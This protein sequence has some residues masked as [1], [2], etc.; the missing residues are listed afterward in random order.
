MPWELEGITSPLIGQYPHH[1]TF[2]LCPPVAI[3][4]RC[5]GIHLYGS[6][7]CSSL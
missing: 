2:L 1:M 3:V 4:K 5:Y 7:M 6:Q